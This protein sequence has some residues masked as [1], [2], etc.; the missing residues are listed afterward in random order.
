MG[1]DNGEEKKKET[2]GTFL[3]KAV[4][5]DDGI[6]LRKACPEQN[7]F[8]AQITFLQGYSMKK[9]YKLTKGLW[10]L[11]TVVSILLV[12][13][14]FLIIYSSHRNLFVIHGYQ[15]KVARYE[16]WLATSGKVWIRDVKY[17]G[18]YSSRTIYGGMEGKAA[19]L[20]KFI[21]RY[22]ADMVICGETEAYEL[23]QAGYLASVEDILGE[24]SKDY[25]S[26]TGVGNDGLYGYKTGRGLDVVGTSQ[27][28]KLKEGQYITV[29]ESADTGR[30]KKSVLVFLEYYYEK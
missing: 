29:M 25:K 2:F 8:E 15:D 23:A 20:A 3:E 4:T 18:P 7:T 19:L 22:E 24:D 9:Y 17:L 13:S 30:T 11:I 14:V 16:L 10:V 6:F 5:P 26:V 1:K 21:D 27:S 12:F 28:L